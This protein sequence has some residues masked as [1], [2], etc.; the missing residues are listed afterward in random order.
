MYFEVVLNKTRS[1]IFNNTIMDLILH[2]HKNNLWQATM[3]NENKK[4]GS[5]EKESLCFERDTEEKREQINSHK[6]TSQ[7]QGDL[8]KKRKRHRE[9]D[10]EEEKG[11]K[12]GDKRI[13]VLKDSKIKKKLKEGIAQLNQSEISSSDD[14]SKDSKISDSVATPHT[15]SPIKSVK[16][17]SNNSFTTDKYPE[18]FQVLKSPLVEVSLDSSLMLP[19]N[20][21]SQTKD[22]TPPN[23][24]SNFDKLVPPPSEPEPESAGLSSM[25]HSGSSNSNNNNK[26][27]KHSKKKKSHLTKKHARKTNDKLRSKKIEKVDIAD[28]LQKL[29]EKVEKLTNKFEESE[30]S[31][32]KFEASILKSLSTIESNWKQ[33]QSARTAAGDNNK[34]VHLDDI[35]KPPLPGFIRKDGNEGTLWP[36]YLDL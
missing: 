9:E 24:A 3:E 36:E 15:E 26:H 35:N 5:K 11:N 12:K 16:L 30:Q 22:A 33:L 18:E 27:A 23:E 29:N 32:T 1:V 25:T 8:L 14:I 19:P 13:K 31:R 7:Q 10:N 4:D 17:S 34:N 21:E 20:S 2:T 6:K 28:C